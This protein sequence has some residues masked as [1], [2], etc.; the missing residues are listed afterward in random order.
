[1]Q[2]LTNSEIN[3]KG[4]RPWRNGFHYKSKLLEYK[5]FKA[6]NV[7]FCSYHSDKPLEP[8]FKAKGYRYQYCYGLYDDG[9]VRLA[10][11]CLDHDLCYTFNYMTNV[12]LLKTPTLKQLSK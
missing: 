2:I 1:M 3:K 5:T 10:C 6:K 4:L 11:Y 12:L 9:C 8:I 7:T